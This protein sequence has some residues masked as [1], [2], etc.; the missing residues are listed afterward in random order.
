MNFSSNI[1]DVQSSALEFEQLAKLYVTDEAALVASL[2]AAAQLPRDLRRQIADYAADWVAKVRSAERRPGMIDAFLQE[3]GLSTHEGIILMRLSEA[4]IRTP[5]FATAQEL[6]RD[7]FSDGSWVSHAGR[8]PSAL[9]NSATN[10]L[11][12]TAAWISATGGSGAASLAAK[13]GDRVLH[14][15]VVRGMGIMAEHFVLGSSIENAVRRSKDGTQ[16]SNLFS[17]DMLGEGACTQADAERYY[18]AY[19]RAVRHLADGAQA[20]AS[21]ANSNGI[22]VKLSA[23]HPRYEY[24]KRADCM[25]VLLERIKE[26]ALIAKKAGVGLTLDA[27]EADRLEISLMIFDNLLA[28]PDLAEWDGLGIVVQAYQRRA[29]ATIDAILRCANAAQRRVAVRL[30]KGAYWDMEIKRGQ[31][32]GLESYPV[33]TRKEHTDI[34]YLACARK[35]LS[36]G[37][38]IYPQFATH[39]AHTAAAIIKMADGKSDM[40]FQRLHG[41]GEAL[42][43]VIQSETGISSRV[44]AP[45]GEHKELLPYLVRRLLENGANSSFVNQLLNEDIEID[46]IVRDPIQQ[47]ESSQFAPNPLIPMPRDLFGGVRQSAKGIDLTQSAVVAHMEATMSSLQP[48]K[49]ASLV[50]GVEAGTTVVKILNPACPE[51]EIGTALNASIAD[52]DAAIVA[53]SLS[54]WHRDTTPQ[55]RGQCLNKAADILEAAMPELMALCVAE[56]G[57]TI[58]DAV[59]ELREAIDFSRYYAAEAIKPRMA[60]RLPL[61]IVACIS[62]WNFPLA[63]FIGQVTAALAAG[64][65]VVAKP[66][67]QT[68][69]IAYEAVKILHRA[70]IFKDALHLVIGGPD[71]GAH[72]AGHTGITAICFTGSTATAKRIAAA[73]ADIGLADTVLIAETGGIN[74]MIADSTSLLEQVVNDVVASAFQSAGQRCSACRLVCI[75]AD[76]ADEFERMLA[77]AMAL[78]H[79]GNPARLATDVGPIIDAAAKQNITDYV[80]AMREKFRVIGEGNAVPETGHF[81]SPIAFAVP[82]ISDVTREVF[83][84]VLHVVRFDGEKV[85]A[86]VEEINALGYGLT[87]GVHSRIDGRI[88][89]IAAR[90]Q[91]G[92]IYVNRNQIG[93]VVGV[94]PFGGEGLSGTGPKAGG[95]HYMLRLSQP[96]LP[97]RNNAL[98]NLSEPVVRSAVAATDL[99]P[100]LGK[101]RRA[102]S[103]W[104]HIRRADICYEIASQCDLEDFGKSVLSQFSTLGDSQ[105]LPGPTGEDNSLT[106]HPRGILVC[107]CGGDRALLYQQVLMAIASGNAVLAIVPDAMKRDFDEAFSKAGSGLPSGL[108][109]SIAESS[110][111]A[112]IESP[113][114]GFVLDGNQRAHLAELIARRA[115]AIL[116]VLSVYDD[117]E[118]FFHERTISIDTTAAGG[119]ASLLAG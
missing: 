45:V 21:V 36:A 35:L 6:M 22:S 40:E 79:A 103:D 63:I 112:A 114:A 91:V 51:Q 57:K 66:A 52:V 93:A 16:G 5:D 27:E 10:S 8:S 15:A 82:K 73:R 116:P 42:H 3:Y 99:R 61:G 47:A 77:G 119:N 55:F 81:V 1:S 12:L 100:L 113:V 111:N 89:A 92:N 107:A 86:L 34:S 4:L 69:L 85:D 65:C 39:N 106:L 64:N 84:P 44:Y 37:K 54:K 95:P 32:M 68:P 50:D 13:L 53:A 20:G 58:A 25:P 96:D 14:A 98:V 43:K 9:I 33:F 17:F 115:G 24:A 23:L 48:I 80:E 74:A 117:P 97:A 83:G 70:G 87:L 88:K 41:M 109:S 104:A 105:N 62:P 90:A 31:E 56:A 108:V 2:A 46:D 59:A 18:G 75:Q 102:Q 72:L 118:R 49:A 110:I 38:F 78:L 7:K 19:T 30:V 28:D 76:I 67:A 71:V 26:L 94:Q 60:Q 29:T 101:A 11:R